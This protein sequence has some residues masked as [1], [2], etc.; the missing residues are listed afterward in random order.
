AIQVQDFD[1]AADLRKTE[2]S[3]TQQIQATLA[4]DVVITGIPEVSDEDIA[5]IVSAWTGVPVNAITETESVMMMHLEDT[6]HERVVGQNEAVV[7]VAK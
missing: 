3:L 1:L 7:A 4:D 2:S 6:L 5:D